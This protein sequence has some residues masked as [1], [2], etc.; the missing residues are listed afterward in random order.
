M[1]ILVT[2]GAG[3]IGSHLCEELIRQKRSVVCVDNF[4]DY[5]NPLIKRKNIENLLFQD[6]F[7]LIETDI[8]DFTAMKKIY[9]K[10]S[11]T[12][13]VHLAARAGVRPS[14]QQPLLYEE[15]NVKGTMNLLE[16]SRQFKVPKFILASS[17]SVYGTNKRCHLM[18]RI[19]LITRCPLM[20][21]PKRHAN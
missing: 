16:L 19:M 10:H 18:N 4:N 8:L 3:F 2:G 21:Q 15:V 12:A 6:G 1:K 5:Y 14:I 17:S 13:I 20:Q 9:Q 11:F 7:D